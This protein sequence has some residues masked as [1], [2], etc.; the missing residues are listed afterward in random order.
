MKV[1]AAIAEILRRE[2]ISSI[3]AY[4]LNFIT[5]F[6][7]DIDIRTVITR[8]ERIAGHMA[9]AVSRVTSGQTI[10]VYATQHGPGIENGFGAVAQA[11]GESVPLLVIPMGYDRKNLNVEPNFSAVASLRTVAKSVE[12]VGSGAELPNI[13]RRAFSQLRNGRGGP[14]VVEVPIDMWGEEVHE[15]LDYQPVVTTRWGPDPVDVEKAANLLVDARRP[16]LYVGQGV[17]YSRAWSQL[18]RLAE[19][20]GVPVMTSLSGKSS[21][22]EDHPLALGSG[23]FAVPGTVPHFL[24]ASDL[25]FGI[26]CSFTESAFATAMPKGKTIIHSTLDPKHIDKDQR[27]NLA[28]VGDAMLTLEALIAAVQKRVPQ[29]RSWSPIQEEIASVRQRWLAEWMPKLTSNENPINPYRVIA[30]LQHI[31]D[32]KNTVITHDAGT[33]RDVLSPFWVSTEPLS[34]IGWGK[35]TQLGYG[36]GLALGAKLAQPEKLCI[37]VWGDASIGFTGMDFETAVREKLP[38]LSILFNNF[39]MAMELAQ[40]GVSTKKYRS[41]DISGNYA[42]LARAL[43]GY[44]ERITEPGEIVAAIKR[45]IEQT[46]KGMPALLEFITCQEVKMSRAPGV[47]YVL[48]VPKG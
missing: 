7:A 36:L 46:R 20:L 17:H 39:S 48:P 6:A 38:I 42:D 41:T 45:G 40:M 18:K 8:A 47:H 16:V 19:H 22:P 11:Y 12:S 5:E 43:G 33:P 1:G 29:Q 3:C 25:I 32:P 23:G 35:T 28:L 2:G 44:G 10:G 26:G 34:Y 14:V 9:D 4:P 15:P 31:V 30:E 37:N 13:M 27:V 24:D 21:F